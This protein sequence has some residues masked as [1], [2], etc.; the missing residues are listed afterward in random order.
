MMVIDVGLLNI[1]KNS[2]VTFMAYLSTI[3]LFTK[4]LPELLTK[5]NDTKQ[6]VTLVK[7]ILSIN[8]NS[9]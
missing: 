5:I 2:D 4:M 8:K 6:I 3:A 1:F 7:L 9:S